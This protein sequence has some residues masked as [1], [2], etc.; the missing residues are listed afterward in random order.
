[1]VDPG[2]GVGPP[3]ST[4]LMR[5]APTTQDAYNQPSD[6]TA[7]IADAGASTTR[8]TT[9]LPLEEAILV[10]YPALPRV[11]RWIDGTGPRAQTR[12]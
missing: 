10:Q 7:Q 8:R 6:R 5:D 12:A 3:G 2:T 9:A 1:M 11:N 4:S